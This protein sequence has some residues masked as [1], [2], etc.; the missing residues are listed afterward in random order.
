MTTPFK[1]DYAF[2]LTVHTANGRKVIEH[3]RRN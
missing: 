1:N 2:G 3:G